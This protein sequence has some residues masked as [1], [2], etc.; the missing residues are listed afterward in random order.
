MKPT[1]PILFGLA[2]AWIVLLLI[3]RITGTATDLRIR[4]KILPLRMIVHAVRAI[5]SL[6]MVALVVANVFMAI[7]IVDDEKH[8]NGRCW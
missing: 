6:V 1:K 2:G 7:A 3:D 8:K 5:K 4:R